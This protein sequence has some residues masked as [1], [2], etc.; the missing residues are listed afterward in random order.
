MRGERTKKQNKKIIFSEVSKNNEVR[1]TI[2]ANF[3]SIMKVGS[4]LIFYDDCE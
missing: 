1:A 4:T 3:N 2:N